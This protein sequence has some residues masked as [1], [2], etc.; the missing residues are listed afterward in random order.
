MEKKCVTTREIQDYLDGLL[1]PTKTVEFEEHLEECRVC[2]IRLREF[3]VLFKGLEPTEI[4]ELPQN[5]VN[6]TMQFVKQESKKAYKRKI[7]SVS[8]A[9]IAAI[10][11][12]IFLP[13]GSFLNLFGFDSGPLPQYLTE[14][15]LEFGIIMNFITNFI[16]GLI[17]LNSGMKGGQLLNGIIFGGIAVITIIFLKLKDRMRII[18]QLIG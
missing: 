8:I 1:S 12:L 13:M 5:F 10:I 18:H 7:I 15:K 3:E 2:R 17:V 6:D 16:N 9:A 11:M 14:L 4:P